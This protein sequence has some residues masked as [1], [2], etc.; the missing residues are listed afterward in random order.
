MSYPA[1]FGLPVVAIETAGPITTDDVASTVW[2]DGVSHTGAVHVRGAASSGYPKPGLTVQV[3]DHL[4]LDAWGLGHPDHLVLATTFDDNSYVRQKL[5]YDLWKAMSVA[6]GDARLTPRTAFVVVYVNGAYNGLYVAI[7][8]ID[9]RFLGDMGS[10]GG[11]N[12]FKAIDHNANFRL[13]DVNGDPKSDLAQGYEQKEGVDAADL[14]DLVQFVGTADGP[15]FA[16]GVDAHLDRDEFIDWYLFVRFV[17]GDDSGGKNDYLYH[18]PQTGRF[19]YIPWDFNHSWG[20]D[21]MTLRFPP[22]VAN[23]FRWN[24]EVFVH[25]QDD[26][27]GAAAIDARQAV[28]VQGPFADAALRAML[29]G[30]YAAID[31]S[32]RRDWSVWGGEYRVYGGW[33]GWRGDDWTDYDGEK[34]YVYAWVDARA[35]WTASDNP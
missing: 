12:L 28:D 18:D 29:D 21:W 14:R 25:L 19:R 24:N 8:R 26:P 34:A 5:C 6:S 9:D 15:T 11:G 20:Q 3:D 23:D 22:D 7:D 31:R 4:D 33:A 32:A 10:V 2:I 1:E 16:A 35:A 13:T 17:A 27:E 30:Y